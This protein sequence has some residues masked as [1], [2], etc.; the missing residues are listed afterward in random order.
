M[1]KHTVRGEVTAEDVLRPG[2]RWR[3]CELWDG[4]PMVRE[5]SGGWAE[6][7]GVRIVSRLEAHVR[8]RD[9]GWV[10][11]S[12]QGSVKLFDIECRAA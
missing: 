6:L 2:S 8:A 1:S 3:E 4:M 7:A 10:F 12:S 9:L 5:P 11:M